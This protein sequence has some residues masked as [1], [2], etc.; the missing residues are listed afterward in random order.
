MSFRNLKEVI[1]RLIFSKIEQLK[2]TKTN[3][4]RIEEVKLDVS[5][6][7]FH[8]CRKIAV[9]HRD[10][11]VVRHILKDISL[12]L[13][14]LQCVRTSRD[15]GSADSVSSSEFDSDWSIVTP[16]MFRRK[17]VPE[18]VAASVRCGISLAVSRMHRFIKHI[19]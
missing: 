3:R 15:L 16:V 5:S 10:V 18:V 17:T 2:E 12:I 9:K 11:S 7:V 1:L 8:P 6:I 19:Q 4:K 14:S 13:F